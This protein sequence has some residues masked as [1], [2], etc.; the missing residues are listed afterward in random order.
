MILSCFTRG[1]YLAPAIGLAARELSLWLGKALPGMCLRRTRSFDRADIVL[2]TFG[3]LS[4][5]VPGLPADD[6]DQDEIVVWSRGRHLVLAGSNPRSVLFAVYTYLDQLG[7]AWIVPG[8]EGERVPRLRHVPLCGFDIRHR[9][10]LR[11]RGFALAGAYSVEL[12][13]AFIAWM[14]RNRFNHFFLEGATCRPWFEKAAGPQPTARIRA[15]DRRIDRAVKDRGLM[16]E[17]M[18]HGWTRWALGVPPGIPAPRTFRLTAERERLVARNADGTPRR[19][20]HAQ[21]CLSRPDAHA[22]MTRRVCQY[23]KAHPEVDVLG[24]WMADGF[25]NWCECPHCATTHP[26]DLWVRLINRLAREVY[27]VRPD[28]R[29]EVLGY[30]SLMEPPHQPVDNSRGNVILMYA[31]FLRCYLH[32][33]DDPRCVSDQPLQTF[34]PVNRLHHPLNGEFF[35]FFKGWRKQFAGVNYVFDYY[36]WLPIKRDI[37]EGDVARAV[38][39]DLTSYPAHGITGCIDCSRAQSFWPT[40]LMRWLQARASW[41]QATDYAAERRRLLRLAFG[42]HAALADRYLTRVYDCLLPERHGR[43]EERAFSPAKVRRFK[44]ALPTLVQSLDRAVT[45]SRGPERLFL[46]RLAVHAR[47]TGLHLNQLLAEA[48]GQWEEAKRWAE[49]MFAEALRHRR[50]LTGVADW[51]EF[52]WLRRDTLK[53]LD[54]K[55]AGTYRRI[56]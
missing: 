31:P 21:L 45:A 1:S 11:H 14:A 42:R 33:L 49:A 56:D 32:R 23:A 6:P 53:R 43:E 28:L 7:F 19:S 35:E 52:E 54:R 20:F 9:A 15:W 22:A 39:A 4:A 55:A 17:K 13:E 37:F 36:G 27:R 44:R 29:I 34:P 38:C 48:A 40:P 10:A 3:S 46:K 30:S 18:G 8:R 12:G 24:V 25:N 5:L 50:L 2:G 51:P 41:D 16:L 47:F 26:S